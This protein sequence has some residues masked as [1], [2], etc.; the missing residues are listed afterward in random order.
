MSPPPARTTANVRLLAPDWCHFTQRLPRSR[1]HKQIKEADVPFED[2]KFS[3]V[4]LTRARSRGVPPACWRSPS[5]A[6]SR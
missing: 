4:A 5:S 3:Y 2:E 6:R 1:A